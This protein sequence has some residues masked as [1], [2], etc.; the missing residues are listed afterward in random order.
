MS[1]TGAGGLDVWYPDY[2]T[3]WSEASCKNERPL[4]SGRPTY[5]SLLQCCRGA[6]GGQVSGKCIAMLDSPP[7]LSPTGA[8]GLDFY[9]PDYDTAWSIATCK[10]ERPLPFLHGGRPTYTTMLAC[11]KGACEI[12]FMLCCPLMTV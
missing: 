2:G 9:Y 1:P 3:A 7:T 12:P 5:D 4:P 8:G 10:N 6:Y 11:C